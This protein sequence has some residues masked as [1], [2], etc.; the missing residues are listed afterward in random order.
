MA[1]RALLVQAKSPNTYWGFQYCLPA[2]KKRAAHLPLGLLTLGG[3]LPRSWQLD[4]IDLNFQELTDDHLRQTDVVLVSG[5]L[6]Q[7]PSI[8]EVLAR[9]RAAGVRS[10]VG[11]PAATAC[12]DDFP[13]ADHVFLGEAEGRLD[14]LIASLEA[15]TPPASRSLSPPNLD[16]PPLVMCKVPRFELVDLSDYASPSIQYSRGC[17]FNCEFCDVVSLFG[18]KPRV[19]SP[20]QVIAELEAIRSTGY[21]G[22][23]F[24]VD[25]NFIGNRKHVNKLLP[26]IEQWQEDNGRPFDFYTEASLDL[27]SCPDLMA[28]MNAAGFSSVFIGIESPSTDALAE[29]GKR[30]NLKRNL[31]ESVDTITRAGIEVYAG[32]IVGFDSDGPEIFEAQREFI[33]SLPIP[34]AMVGMLTALPGTPLWQRLEREGR[35]R[36]EA[37]GNQF[38][39]PNFIP[40]MDEA[41]LIRG[42]RSLLDS[43]YSVDAYF[44]R[45]EQV[46]DRLGNNRSGEVKGYGISMLARASYQLGA[47]SPRTRRR[48]WRL[49]KKALKKSPGL[50]PR[51]IA[52]AF[53]GE[54]L[55]RYTQD[56]VLPALDQALA[57]LGQNTQDKASEPSRIKSAIASALS[58]TAPITAT[59]NP[60]LS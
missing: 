53:M 21:R 52:M 58:P 35:L 6:V 31:T 11:G 27:S 57:E 20:D 17:P 47:K 2:A 48:Y 15:P 12:P 50:L 19:K 16:R 26:V 56:D 43:L 7:A 49:L 18:R 14:E 24:F 1:I 39:R 30:Q 23:L 44:D 55:I 28:S 29:T 3:L 45:C 10:V 5:M 36:G 8:R 25:D 37:S 22:S 33:S 40:A 4:L 38:V 54:H 13:D 9:T 60:E 42:Y 34:L 59:T 32:F 41:T 51:A 46:I